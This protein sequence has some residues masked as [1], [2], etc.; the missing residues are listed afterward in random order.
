M[1]LYVVSTP[2]G[3]LKDI[4]FRA[5]E[6]LNSV[7]VIIAED[8]RHTKILLREYDIETPMQSFHAQSSE[9]KFKYVLSLIQEREVALV[10]D[11]GTP[12]ISDPG[13]ILIHHAVERNIDVIPVPGPAAYLTALTGSGFH[14]LKHTFLGFIPTKKGRLT[15]LQNIK[16]FDQTVIFYESCHRVNKL[17]EQARDIDFGNRE[18]CLARELTKLHESWYRGTIK[19]LCSMEIPTKGEFVVLVNK[20]ID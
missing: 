13:S 12:G 6:V 17:L 14:M 8:T 3:N 7:D 4:T 2:I 20:R 5:I 18:W 19:E 9:E 1:S 11:A 10:T 15:F 16:E